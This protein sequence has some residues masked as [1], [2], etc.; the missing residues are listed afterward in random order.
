MRLVADF[1]A[2]GSLSLA[3]T[4]T[5]TRAQQHLPGI[6]NR[7]QASQDLATCSRE[8]NQLLSYQDFHTAVSQLHSQVQ[9]LNIDELCSGNDGNTNGSKANSR[10]CELDFSQYSSPLQK[11]CGIHQGQFHTSQ[12]TVTCFATSSSTAA[13]AAKDAAPHYSIQLVQF[14]DCF[15]NSCQAADIDRLVG[16]NVRQY[17]KSLALNLDKSLSS[18]QGVIRYTCYSDASPSATEEE[19]LQGTI[20]EEKASLQQEI[21]GALDNELAHEEMKDLE[22]YLTNHKTKEQQQQQTPQQ[23]LPT[24]SS[25]DETSYDEVASSSCSLPGRI[26][27]VATVITAAVLRWIV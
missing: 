6:N 21:E 12:H 2:I 27:M 16:H 3:L 11:A 15:G 19:F 22:G 14:P 4:T 5:T 20:E 24:T 23:H 8:S 26:P 1:V 17:E 7:P 10:R 25:A 18:Q 9:T 13:A